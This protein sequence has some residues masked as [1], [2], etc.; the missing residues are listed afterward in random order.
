MA[1]VVTSMQAA[2]LELRDAESLREHYPLTLRRWLNNLQADSEQA[3]ALVGYQRE[4]AWQLYV[5]GCAQ[6][7]EAGEITVYQVLAARGDAPHGLPLDRTE[8]LSGAP[9]GLSRLGH[10]H[11]E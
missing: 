3:V 10:T 11:D 8:L 4:R 6:A 9:A 2:G 7:F 5:L 1:D